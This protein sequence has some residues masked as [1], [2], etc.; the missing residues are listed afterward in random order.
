[1]LNFLR[2]EQCIKPNAAVQGIRLRSAILFV[3]DRTVVAWRG[4][5]R[6]ANQMRIDRLARDHGVWL[7]TA[8]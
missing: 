7:L 8:I 1:M 2:F 6:T 5:T 4:A 3:F